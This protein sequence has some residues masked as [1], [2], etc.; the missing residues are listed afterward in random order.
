MYK[1]CKLYACDLGWWKVTWFS[2]PIKL[3][4]SIFL[5][6]F[7]SV[8][9]PTVINPHRIGMLLWGKL[10][11]L[12]E[13]DL[14]VVS[15][16]LARFIYRN[17]VQC[18]Q[19]FLISHSPVWMCLACFVCVGRTT[20]LPPACNCTLSGQHHC[21]DRTT[22]HVRNQ[23]WEK[24]LAIMFSIEITRLFWSQMHTPFLW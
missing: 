1:R 9:L 8:K 24:H 15:Y 10:G 23:R 22:A 5:G 11:G 21:H 17:K 7:C 19:G 12:F 14:K 6:T 16:L 18:K 13:L 3:T 20:Q 2:A 4:W